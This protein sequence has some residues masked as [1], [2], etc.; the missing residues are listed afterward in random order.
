MEKIREFGAARGLA[1]AQVALVWV[2]SRGKDIIP[3]VGT[4]RQDNLMQAIQCMETQLSPAEVSELETL[5]PR[6]AAAG[7]R[8]PEALMGQLNR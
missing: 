5:V 3:L 7:S 6:N 4:R 2:L 8:Y 1:P